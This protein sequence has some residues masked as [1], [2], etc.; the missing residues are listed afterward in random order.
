[1][2]RINADAL[3]GTILL[4]E[5][6]TGKSYLLQHHALAALARKPEAKLIYVRGTFRNDPVIEVHATDSLAVREELGLLV[7]EAERMTAY[8]CDAEPG[9][10]GE[11]ARLEGKAAILNVLN[12]TAR[13][14]G[15]RDYILAVDEIDAFFRDE[16]ERDTLF[17]LLEKSL[18]S[19]ARLLTLMV[20]FQT[21]ESIVSLFGPRGVELLSRLEEKFVFKTREVLALEP[22]VGDRFIITGRL[23][24]G[25]ALHVTTEAAVLVNADLEP[26][27]GVSIR[28]H[29][30]KPVGFLR[31]RQIHDENLSAHAADCVF[32]IAFPAAI[33]FAVFLFVQHERGWLASLGARPGTL[34]FGGAMASAFLTAAAHKL[35][36]PRLARFLAALAITRA[37]SRLLN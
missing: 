9:L 11:T 13:G 2:Q 3:P 22:F 4:G 16:D 32:L 21:V 6:A 26:D 1:M 19:D 23:R 34:L 18:D 20:T 30:L 25:E 10:S 36:A 24:R 5:P 33:A 37:G 29:A 35:A 14:D 7:I 31:V 8:I 28:P 15:P 27:G 17:E 12:L